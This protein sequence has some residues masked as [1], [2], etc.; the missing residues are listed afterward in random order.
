MR[1]GVYRYA[2][3]RGVFQ[4]AIEHAIR[5]GVIRQ[6]SDGTID[7]EQADATWYVQHR[8][9]LEVRARGA[10][11]GNTA[12]QVQLAARLTKVQLAKTNYETRE[13]DYVERQEVRTLGLTQ[14]DRIGGGL[15]ALIA[16]QPAQL[17]TVE[18]L[19]QQ[20]A[21]ALLQEFVE[22][23]FMELGDLWDEAR[24]AAEAL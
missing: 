18:G 12:L 10:E 23:T 16:A 20:L 14:A 19:D 17:V 6:D 21:E 24:L 15:R 11:Q 22:E 5:T 7:S 9:R 2:K 13:R 3:L 1:I 8:A 4:S